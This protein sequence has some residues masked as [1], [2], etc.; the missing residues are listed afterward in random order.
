MIFDKKLVITKNLP[1]YLLRTS[2]ESY[3]SYLKRIDQFLSG[4]NQKDL[5]SLLGKI[6]PTVEKYKPTCD[7]LVTKINGKSGG[8]C[9]L[10]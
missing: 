2:D 6:D 1:K 9:N 3:G 10:I 8:K 4:Y 5:S 7:Y